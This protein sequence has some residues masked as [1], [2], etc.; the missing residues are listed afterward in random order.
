MAAPVRA[1][2]EGKVQR[3]L[4]A[5]PT[6]HAAV[7]ASAA[8]HGGALL[9]EEHSKKGVDSMERKIADKVV[10]ADFS[11][12]AA[13]ATIR[14]SV[15]FTAV[16]PTE[17]YWAAGTKIGDDLEAAGYQRVKQTTGW[18]LNSV[19]WGRNDTFVGA[20][21]VEFELQFHTEESRKAGKRNHS[22]YD[23]TRQAGTPQA[24][25]DELDAA[26]LA[27]LRSAVTIPD[28]LP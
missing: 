20:D 14:D 7:K 24:A 11:P 10:V 25:V 22:M 26:Q 3:A 28:D 8:S 23:I 6:I 16:L 9:G 19:Y 4:A 27:Y 1:A 15:R 21:G 13:A 18:D 2:A 5:E 17:G 12:E